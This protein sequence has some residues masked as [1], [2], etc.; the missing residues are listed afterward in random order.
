MYS[1]ILNQACGGLLVNDRIF[2]TI[3]IVF[4]S[5][6]VACR[7]YVARTAAISPSIKQSRS[8]CCLKNLRYWRNILCR[9]KRRLEGNMLSHTENVFHFGRQ[10]K[11]NNF[12]LQHI[13][14]F[15]RIP[16][17]DVMNVSCKNFPFRLIVHTAPVGRC[18]YAKCKSDL[19]GSERCGN[20]LAEKYEDLSGNVRRIFPTGGK[21]ASLE[22]RISRLVQRTK[23]ES[24]WNRNGFRS[25]VVS[26]A[27]WFGWVIVRCRFKENH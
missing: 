6:A 8:I 10:T 19:S 24:V 18:I 17:V 1:Q 9:R 15:G 11:K 26:H 14:L 20:A 12:L 25:V 16:L 5:Q 2:P 22:R 4:I 21:S 27:W 7:N 3:S 23:R 13:L